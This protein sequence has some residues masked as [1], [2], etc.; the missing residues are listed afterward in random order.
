MP[1]LDEVFSHAS[2]IPAHL[3]RPLLRVDGE[4]VA[5]RFAG[6]PLA[7]VAHEVGIDELEFE[8]EADGRYRLIRYGDLEVPAESI[9]ATLEAHIEDEH[10]GPEELEDENA[11][12]F[13]EDEARAHLQP[14]DDDDL[15]E[16]AEVEIGRSTWLQAADGPPPSEAEGFALALTS[17]PILFGRYY[18]FVEPERRRIRQVFQCT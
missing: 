7:V 1:T 12:L 10:G 18:L 13:E 5:A 3:L 11:E 2:S 14:S 6:L 8:V 17:H 16:L 9:R 15:D 4:A